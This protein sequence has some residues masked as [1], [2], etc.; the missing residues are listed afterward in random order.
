MAIEIGGEYVADKLLPKHFEKLAKDAELAK[1]R[2]KERVIELT[3]IVLGNL[4]KIEI[5]NSIV[6]D[7]ITL[8]KSRC[9]IIMALK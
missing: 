3:N 2:V 7:I 8:I 1:P 5:D 6:N 9:E 4:D